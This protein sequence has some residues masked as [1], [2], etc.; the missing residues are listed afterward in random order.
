MQPYERLIAW[1]AAVRF[2]ERVEPLVKKIARHAPARARQLSRAADSVEDNTAEGGSATTPRKKANYFR[3]ARDS[4]GE[5]G[6]Q[7]RR[8]LR[9]GW[10]TF[11]EWSAAQIVLNEVTFL[12]NQL[13]TKWEA[14]ADD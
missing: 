13:V 5:C 1:Q 6:G 3:I 2:N 9:K 10:I 7:L 4:A 8:A 12:L 14:E 11:A